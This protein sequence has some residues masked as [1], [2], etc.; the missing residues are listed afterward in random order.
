MH[1]NSAAP[2][3]GVGGT[4]PSTIGTDALLAWEEG[5]DRVA[6]TLPGLP[7]PTSNEDPHSL[8][9]DFLSRPLGDQQALLPSNLPIAAAGEG[10]TIPA[11]SC[12]FSSPGLSCP[13][14]L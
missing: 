14:A 11:Q 13:L 3:A 2:L 7:V 12:C 10:S 5:G 1:G 4:H 9:A 6:R 8:T